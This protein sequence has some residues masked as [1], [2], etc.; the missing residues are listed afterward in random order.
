MKKHNT[1]SK[2]TAG[3]AMVLALGLSAAL[4]ASAALTGS[5]TKTSTA[6][7]TKQFQMP[8]GTIL[9]AGIKFEFSIKS[10]SEDG[11]APSA[12]MQ[13]GDTKVSDTE[14]KS[15]ITF[16]GTETG[17][18]DAKDTTSYY[19]E[20]AELFRNVKWTHP[21]V[22]E[23]EVTEIADTYA[24]NAT[25]PPTEAMTYSKAV[26]TM[27]VYVIEKDGKYVIDYIS[28]WKTIDDNGDEITDQ[29]KVD[30]TPK[31]DRT[32]GKYSEMVF[33]NSYVKTN[34]PIDPP[35]D[36]PTPEDA[37]LSVSKEV[38][39]TYGDS[40]IYFPFSMTVTAPDLVKNPPAYKAAVVERDPADACKCIIVTS[41]SN[42]AG[43]ID[44][45]GYI[46]FT[47]GAAP[48]SFNLKHGQFLA[49][50]NTPVG[51]IYEV[52][53]TGTA[54]YTAKAK[55]TTNGVQ[56]AQEEAIVGQ[57]LMLPKAS[58]TVYTDKLYV[59]EAKNS[60]DFLNDRGTTTPT[61]ISVDNLPFIVL[62]GLAAAGL[63]GFVVLKSRRN[64]QHDA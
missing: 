21:G 64:K 53:E 33:V 23:Y 22:Y 20:S 28:A 15:T 25:P 39:G 2:L 13:A 47:S 48:P 9:P 54:L 55:V 32:D 16:A 14:G 34:G 37:T 49:F 59:G 36:P 44:A 56:G 4:P 60:A 7:I 46:S 57:D 10:K 42:Y 17:T 58:N 26:Y 18:T 52:K 63:A 61:G 31:D 27:F 41:P 11:S 51:T 6:A 38:A 19:K 24:V 1:I 29:V 8:K 5:P 3:I 45:D 30:P 35:V 40:T 50:I 43:A 62:I 12:A